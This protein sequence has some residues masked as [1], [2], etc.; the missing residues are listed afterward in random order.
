MSAFYRKNP[1]YSEYPKDQKQDAVT[2]ELV[3]D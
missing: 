1:I 3:S 2:R